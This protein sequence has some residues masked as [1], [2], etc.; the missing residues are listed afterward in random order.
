MGGKDSGRRPVM[1]VG[2]GVSGYGGM[3]EFVWSVYQA[4]SLDMHVRS[5]SSKPRPEGC[6]PVCCW[7]P[8]PKPSRVEPIASQVL[9]QGAGSV[10]PTGTTGSLS[11]FI[12]LYLTGELGDP[13]LSLTTA[14]TLWSG[15]GTALVGIG[16]SAGVTTTLCAVEPARSAAPIA[17]M[18]SSGS[19]T[20]SN[21]GYV[22]LRSLCNLDPLS[23]RR[24]SDDSLDSSC[25]LVLGRPDI[26]DM[27]QGSHLFASRCA[28][29]YHPRAATGGSAKIA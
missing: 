5:S 21:L 15:F 6:V 7:R 11:G 14:G 1:C 20:V 2:G 28:R 16:H 18:Y 26:S 9:L 13:L 8:C 19:R 22:F 29:E 12:T 24:E 17:S 25:R 4:A 3:N 27:L 23:E 10:I